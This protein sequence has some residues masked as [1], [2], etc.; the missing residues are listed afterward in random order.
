MSNVLLKVSF[1]IDFSS[2]ARRSAGRQDFAESKP[3]DPQAPLYLFLTFSYYNQDRPLYTYLYMYLSY[4]GYKYSFFLLESGCTKD[5]DCT[6]DKACI[7]GS[8][9]DPCSLRAACGENALCKVVQH[10]PRCECPDCY[11]GKA[12]IRCRKN[13]DCSNVPTLPST[14]ARECTTDQDCA[15][16]LSCDKG[17]CRNPCHSNLNE[18]CPA[19]EECVV[20]NHVA[21]CRCKHKLAINSLGELKC[22]LDRQCI[23][24]E[25]CP[26][27]MA[28]VSGSCRNPC[29]EGSCPKGKRC[30]VLN[31]QPLCMCEK[32][33]QPSVSICLKDRGCP[34]DQACV[35]YKCE[36]P[37]DFHSCP[38]L[39]PCIVQD[40]KPLCK[41]CPEGF[42]ADENYGCLVA[43]ILL[44]SQSTQSLICIRLL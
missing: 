34:S 19:D 38:G 16:T 9:R 14:E 4:F 18:P 35:N 27:K 28:C 36:N 37:C 11:S 13:P 12:H 17:A 22:G 43:G 7:R 30:Q 32:D 3:L 5:S 26:L 20:Q 8:C 33:C 21:T 29:T 15:I 2:N 10:R 23:S 42:I 31:H 24:N 40:H 39:A 25:E 44:T 1:F 41:F 6:L